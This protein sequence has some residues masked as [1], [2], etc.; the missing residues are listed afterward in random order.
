MITRTSDTKV[1]GVAAS[2][3]K[4]QNQYFEIIVI[5]LFMYNTENQNTTPSLTGVTTEDQLKLKECINPL[6]PIDAFRRHK[7]VIL[8]LRHFWTS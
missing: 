8:F 2:N 5:N 6:M 7:N 4:D 1:Q 3:S